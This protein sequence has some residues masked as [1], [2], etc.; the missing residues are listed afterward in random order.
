MCHRKILMILGL[1][2]FSG[3]PLYAADDEYSDDYSD[4]SLDDE[5][6]E[7]EGGDPTMGAGALAGSARESTSGLLGV[8]AG[9]L[10][11]AFSQ[12]RQG[13]LE[14][15]ILTGAMAAGQG[16]VQAQQGAKGVRGG[17]AGIVAKAQQSAQ[18]GMSGAAGAMAAG[19][20][21]AAGGALAGIP[22]GPVPLTTEE[23]YNIF[24][25]LPPAEEELP[26]LV[27][28]VPGEDATAKVEGMLGDPKIAGLGAKRYEFDQSKVTGLTSEERK[29]I[30]AAGFL[31]RQEITAF[32]EDV[33]FDYMEYFLK[34]PP[35]IEKKAPEVLGEISEAKAEALRAQEVA[36]NKQEA[37]RV[38]KEEN[39]KTYQKAQKEFE[40]AR[41]D[42]QLWEEFLSYF[43]DVVLLK[44]EGSME[45]LRE[46][47]KF[48]V[49]G[50]PRKAS[51]I[52]ELE[53]TLVVG[54]SIDTIQ[55][56]TLQEEANARRIYTSI[57]DK[58]KE[59]RDTE[60]SVFGMSDE[61]DDGADQFMGTCAEFCVVVD[62]E[63]NTKPDPLFV[64]IRRK[65]WQARQAE[66][67][68]YLELVVTLNDKFAAEEKEK[69]PEHIGS[70]VQ[71]MKEKVRR[72]RESAGG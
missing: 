50:K 24:M 41:D 43:G 69:G 31:C 13:N 34:P 14:G 18:K 39:Y 17:V 60:Y 52:K 12:L 3:A 36:Q 55:L 33:L 44:L 62:A 20:A 23:L 10:K 54:G 35:K 57:R 29:K 40:K 37:E 26:A 49:D 71:R 53:D 48:D 8:A 15:A 32:Y 64:K 67:G 7:E 6:D 1:L 38:R 46:F 19:S 21:L 4:E 72:A 65:L 66:Q 2:A 9:G 16:T 68:R 51:V 22:T 42:S 30:D 45:S 58:L 47:V 61:D 5:M 25:G 70:R 59:K 11:G 27:D 56:L 28:L 63:E